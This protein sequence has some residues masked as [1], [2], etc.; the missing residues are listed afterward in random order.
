MPPH[1]LL[2][3]KS[4]LEDVYKPYMSFKCFFNIIKKILYYLKC[5][6]GTLRSCKR[7]RANV[8][9]HAEVSMDISNRPAAVEPDFET[10]EGRINHN[11]HN[12]MFGTTTLSYGA[13]RIRRV[14]DF[15]IESC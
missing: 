4:L 1:E 7:Y 9:L 8:D 13:I 3:R 10:V 6:K 5:L 2:G 15:G 11:T 14:S 12:I